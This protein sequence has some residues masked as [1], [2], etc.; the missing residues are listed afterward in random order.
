[1][2]ADDGVLAAMAMFSR[3]FGASLPTLTFRGSDRIATFCDGLDIVDPG[4]VPVPLWRPDGAD[5]DTDRNPEQ[6]MGCA[7]LARKP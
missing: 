4:I 3:M 1:M 6:F 5:P 7:V 2:G